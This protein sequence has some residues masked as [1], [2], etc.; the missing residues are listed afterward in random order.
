MKTTTKW[1]RMSSF[2]S[3]IRNVGGYHWHHGACFNYYLVRLEI[4]I[5]W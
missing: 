3:I 1:A 5:F 2:M 4:I